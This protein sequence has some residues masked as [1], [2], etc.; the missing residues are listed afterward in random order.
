LGITHPTSFF[1]VFLVMVGGGAGGET[2][3]AQIFTQRTWPDFAS[4]YF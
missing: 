4:N 1:A 3:G 2:S